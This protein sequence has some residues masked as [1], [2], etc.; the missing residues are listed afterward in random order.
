MSAVVLL[1]Q[2]VAFVRASF[3]KQR[4]KEVRKY[5]GEFSTAEMKNVSYDC[6]AILL[7]VLGW[8]KPDAGS[9]MTGRHAKQ[10]RLAAFVV[11]KNAKSREARMAE[12]MLLAEDLGVLLRQW[13]PMV[14]EP[15]ASALKALDIQALGLEDEPSCENLYNRAVDEQGQ[16]LWLVDWFQCV[17]GSVPIS[18]VRPSVPYADLPDLTQVDIEDT[19]H[20]NR[21]PAAPPSGGAAP[22]VTE[23]IDFVNT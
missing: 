4:A 23:K 7:T 11:T 10:V 15:S 16:A 8:K 18:P 5:A 19:T 17:R 22:V 20:V 6:P 13:A 9:R 12:A 14:Q 2:A 3:P 21:V 1:D